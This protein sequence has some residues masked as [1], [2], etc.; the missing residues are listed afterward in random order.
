MKTMRRAEEPGRK[1]EETLRTFNS[2][3]R[4]MRDRFK[5]D[6]RPYYGA[7][8][9]VLRSSPRPHMF[10]SPTVNFH[11]KVFPFS[12][13]TRDLPSRKSPSQAITLRIPDSA[14]RV[15]KSLL[16]H[17]EQL[18]LSPGTAHFE[19]TFLASCFPVVHRKSFHGV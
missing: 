16:N 15:P 18:P 19:I 1:E 7:K 2:F 10:S 3:R 5:A 8:R 11:P 17:D 14:S 12:E 9:Q 6:E 13:K 4:P